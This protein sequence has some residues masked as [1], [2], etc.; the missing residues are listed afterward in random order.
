MA[1]A[2]TSGQEILVRQWGIVRRMTGNDQD[3]GT[4]GPGAFFL[5]ASHLGTQATRSGA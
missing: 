2:T 1:N 3:L 4:E 5:R